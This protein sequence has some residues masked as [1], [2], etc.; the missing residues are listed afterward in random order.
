MN[1]IGVFIFSSILG[2]SYSA[3][4]FGN[5]LDE[6]IINMHELQVKQSTP[7]Q[8]VKSRAER[9][10]LP[11]FKQKLLDSDRILNRE[12]RTQDREEYYKNE[13]MR[14]DLETRRLKAK[15]AKSIVDET[16]F[17][18]VREKSKIDI[19]LR[20]LEV[21]SRSLDVERKGRRVAQDEN[22]KIDIE[23]RKLDLERKKKRVAQEENFILLELEDKAAK[24]KSE[25]AR[26]ES[27]RNISTG[28]RTSLEGIGEAAKHGDLFD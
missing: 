26:A 8:N 9:N 20:Q 2:A 10:K 18:Y 14:L 12:E 5:S 6:Q 1:M 22:F 3:T 28:V 21:E 4:T 16:D 15:V 11:E 7:N 13:L 19:E 23:L 27:T 25:E 17:T 24:I